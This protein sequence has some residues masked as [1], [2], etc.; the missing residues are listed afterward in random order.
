MKNLPNYF[1][2]RGLKFYFWSNEGNEPIH[3]HIAPGRPSKSSTKFWLL[4][5]G[6]CKLA[7]NNANLT[8]K[9]LKYVERFIELNFDDFLDTWKKFYSLSTVKFYK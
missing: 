1:T 9:Q 3:V 2:F 5:N 6:K 8:K 7:N 4:A